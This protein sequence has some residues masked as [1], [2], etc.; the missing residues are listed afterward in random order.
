MSVV[1]SRQNRAALLLAFTPSFACARERAPHHAVVASPVQLHL[2]PELLLEFGETLA[3]L[4]RHAGASLPTGDARRYV[5][6][7]KVSSRGRPR[8]YAGRPLVNCLAL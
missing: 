2:L 6:G 7:L 5:D 1:T 3:H 4:H 8:T